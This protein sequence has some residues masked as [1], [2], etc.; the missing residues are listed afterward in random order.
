MFTVTL[1]DWTER[2]ALNRSP[3]PVKMI[4]CSNTERIQ[5]KLLITK[6]NFL[7]LHKM[8]L[9]T[10]FFLARIRFFI[11]PEISNDIL[12][13]FPWFRWYFFSAKVICF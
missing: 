4:I 12:K 11:F 3:L 1:S 10:L 13:K 7:F 8:D 6:C 5:A 9:V 2:L